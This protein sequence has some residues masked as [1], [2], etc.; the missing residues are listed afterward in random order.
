MVME[1]TKEENKRLCERYP[2]LIPWN[3]WSG[4]R[5]TEAQNGGYWA[6]DPTKIPEYDYEYTELDDMPDGGLMQADEGSVEESLRD[7]L[8]NMK[9]EAEEDPGMTSSDDNTQATQS[10]DDSLSE[11]TKPVGPQDG[12]GLDDIDLDS[13]SLEDLE[14]GQVVPGGGAL[15]KDGG[16]VQF[17]VG[18]VLL[19]GFQDADGGVEVETSF[20][21]RQRP[22]QLQQPAGGDAARR[23]ILDRGLQGLAEIAPGH[24]VI[25]DLTDEVVGD[26]FCGI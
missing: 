14:A 21:F 26:S 25:G 23:V 4:M 11:G 12:S 8:D 6:G 2:F 17:P 22:C 20:Q 13:I 9:D 3:R 18:G 1:T 5:I 19:L 7:V 24:P 16:V 10:E 15:G